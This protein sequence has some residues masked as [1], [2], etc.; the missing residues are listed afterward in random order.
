MMKVRRGMDVTMIT[1]IA[2]DGT[3]EIVPMFGKVQ[4]GDQSSQVYT[5][6]EHLARMDGVEVVAT[7]LQLRT[8]LRKIGSSPVMWAEKLGVK[9]SEKI[10]WKGAAETID[11]YQ[12]DGVAVKGNTLYITEVASPS[13][14]S[15]VR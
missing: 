14:Q 11:K 7:N 8:V 3:E 1:K 9:L 13:P 15:R 10:K 6:L 4:G 2:K 12:P 5:Q